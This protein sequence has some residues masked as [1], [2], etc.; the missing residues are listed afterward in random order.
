MGQVRVPRLVA[1][2]C[3]RAWLTCMVHSGPGNCVIDTLCARLLG[4]RCDWDGRFSSI[5]APVDAVH[6]ESHIWSLAAEFFALPPPKSTGRELFN[7]AFVTRLQAAMSGASAHD[8][9]RAAVELT[10]TSIW[11]AVEPFKPDVGKYK[12]IS[13]CSIF[14]IHYC[15]V[16][17][18][19]S[20]CERWRCAQPYIARVSIA[21]LSLCGTRAVG[22][23][24]DWIDIRKQGSRCIC[25]AGHGD[26]SG[27]A[28]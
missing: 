10:A 24:L 21:A 6:F 19:C 12:V 5:G 16:R 22:T 20:C 7:E 18:G 17:F 25:R 11:R 1:C 3:R 15:F 4:E 8:I 26:T 13:Q 9:I 23:Q 27:C 14:N 28:E 2:A